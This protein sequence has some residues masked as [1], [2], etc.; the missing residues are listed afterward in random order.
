[1]ATQGDFVRL[2][3]PLQGELLA[4]VLAQG[5][6]GE[7]ADDVLQ[8]AAVQILNKIGSF[9]AGTNFR[10]WAYAFVRNEVLR[11]FRARPRRALALSEETLR[12]IEDL[13]TAAEPEPRL[14]RLGA[15]LERLQDFARGLISMRYREGLS[16]KAMADRLGRPVDSVYTTLSRVR[17]ALHECLAG[18]PSSPAVAKEEPS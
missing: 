2:F 6:P 18:G 15:C 14:Q 11:H 8:T 17:K 13:S 7:D 4:Y 1:M 9:Q 12:E 16:V 10:A 5:V 3:L